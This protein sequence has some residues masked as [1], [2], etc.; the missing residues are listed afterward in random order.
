VPGTKLPIAMI[1]F[2]FDQHDIIELLKKRGRA[3][4]SFDNDKML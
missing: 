2:D 4:R 3:I 1:E